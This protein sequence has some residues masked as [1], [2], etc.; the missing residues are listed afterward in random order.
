MPRK[1]T[2]TGFSKQ[3]V[4]IIGDS[5]YLGWQ[6]RGLNKM[7]SKSDN[8]FFAGNKF[9]SVFSIAQKN[10]KQKKKTLEQTDLTPLPLLRS[11]CRFFF[12]FNKIEIFKIDKLSF[13]SNERTTISITRSVSLRQENYSL[14]S[15]EWSYRTKSQLSNDTLNHVLSY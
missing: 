8:F 1:K 7:H 5:C 15:L 12:V 9:W 6:N 10:T 13:L 2:K 14:N 11:A 4:G 3:K